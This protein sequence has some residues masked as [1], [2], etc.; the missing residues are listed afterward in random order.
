MAKTSPVVPPIKLSEPTESGND[1]TETSGRLKHLFRDQPLIPIGCAATVGAFLFA[2]R[3]I[4]RGDSMRANRFF[5]Y[6]VLAQAATV[7]AIVGGVFME[8]K[9]K[10]E[11][12][13]EQITPK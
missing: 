11:K 5:R 1:T 3:A 10:Q 8:R 4:R 12:R 6:R 7:L 13:M 2:T 9:M